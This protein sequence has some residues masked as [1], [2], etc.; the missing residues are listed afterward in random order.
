VDDS[1]TDPLAT[2]NIGSKN[3]RDQAREKYDRQC[4]ASVSTVRLPGIESDRMD[5]HHGG[6]AFT[7]AQP[8][9]IAEHGF[10]LP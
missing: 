7:L 5:Y 9:D 4:S 6:F 2:A 10:C 1:N 3:V 8:F